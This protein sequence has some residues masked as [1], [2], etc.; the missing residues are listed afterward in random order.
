VNLITEV[1]R[2]VQDENLITASSAGQL[3]FARYILAKLDVFYDETLEAWYNYFSTGEAKYF[4]TDQV[5]SDL[6][7]VS[8]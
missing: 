5:L 2:A 4:V 6:V 8:A 1:T 3:L 7:G